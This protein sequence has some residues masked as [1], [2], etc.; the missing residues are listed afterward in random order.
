[1]AG[2]VAGV[3]R[4]Y[5]GRPALGRPAL[6]PQT[7]VQQLACM[8]VGGS[9]ERIV[10]GRERTTRRIPRLGDVFSNVLMQQHRTQ[11]DER[12]RAQWPGPSPLRTSLLLPNSNQRQADLNLDKRGL[13]PLATDQDGPSGGPAARL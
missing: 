8:S 12:T 4:G 11:H 2:V 10:R 7:A 9:G 5:G 6:W 13:P 3:G 1:M